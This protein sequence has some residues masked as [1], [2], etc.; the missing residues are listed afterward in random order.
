M[1]KQEAKRKIIEYFTNQGITYRLLNEGQR[2]QELGSID[3][4]YFSVPAPEVISGHIETVLRFR[5]EHVYCQSYYC[6]PVVKQNEE[7]IS[8]ASRIINY[9]NT[10]LFYEYD[11]C[12]A[13]YGHTLA[14][15]EDEG[16][17]YNGSLIRYE[18]LQKFF[19]ETMS[20]IVDFQVQ[21][22]TDICMPVIGYITENMDFFHAAHVWIDCRLMGK[23]IEG[24]YI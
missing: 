18:M 16:D 9:I 11:E 8:R 4:I 2:I 22:L 17:I 6:Q 19:Y 14:L 12:N 20:Y 1:N 13:V 23:N 10:H 24:R 5:E 3:T 21:F 15:N 7:E